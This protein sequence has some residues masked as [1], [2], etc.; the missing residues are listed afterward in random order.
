MVERLLAVFVAVAL[1]G[2]TNKMEVAEG[3]LGAAVAQ[4]TGLYE[5]Q[6]SGSVLAIVPIYAPALSDNVFY[7]QEMAASDS[8][9]ITAQRLMSFDAVKGGKLVQTSWALAQPARWRDGHLQPDLFKS[10]VRED[11]RPGARGELTTEQLTGAELLFD[12]TGRLVSEADGV[13]SL[14]YRR[15]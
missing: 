3:K 7:L 15:R 10:L 2:C 6:E 9:R 14:R 8:R 11:V 12:A 1:V 5:R 13:P 4:F